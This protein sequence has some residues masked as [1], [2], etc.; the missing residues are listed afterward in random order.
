MRNRIGFRAIF[1]ASFHAAALL[2]EI[3]RYVVNFIPLAESLQRLKRAD[4]AAL[5]RRMQKI[6]LH[7]QDLHTVVGM[8]SDASAPFDHRSRRPVMKRSPQI[9]RLS[10]RQMR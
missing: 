9:C 10:S 6:R 2:G 8:A 4:V 7:P 3:K 1:R 5:G